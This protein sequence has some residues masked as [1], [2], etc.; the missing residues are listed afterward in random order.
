MR[1]FPLLAVLCA[2]LLAWAILFSSI[3]FDQQD[4]PLFDDWAF[5]RSALIFAKGEAIDYGHWAAMPQLGQWLWALPFIR[6]LGGSNPA[7]RAATIILSW[8]GL[9]A[10]YDLLSFRRPQAAPVAAF[11]TTV[12]AF[13]PFFFV[14]SGTFMTDIPTLS[15]C[16]IGLSL[17]QRAIEGDSVWTWVAAALIAVLA[18]CTRQN[19]WALPLAATTMLVMQAFASPLLRSGS[20]GSSSPLLPSGSAAP[21]SHLSPSGGRGQGEG[22]QPPTAPRRLRVLSWTAALLPLA[23]GSVVHMWFRARPDVLHPPL[24][25]EWR[26]GAS[27]A[28]VPDPHVVLILPFLL[29]HWLGLTAWPIWALLPRISWR[30]WLL[31]ATILLLCA[32]YWWRFGYIIPHGGLFPYWDGLLSPAGFL[33]EDLVPGKRPVIIGLRLEVREIAY[34]LY[35]ILADIQNYR[36]VAAG[37][38]CFETLFRL[39]TTLTSAVDPAFHTTIVNHSLFR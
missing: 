28:S 5:G 12:L 13:N 19:A 21:F 26:A 20:A 22:E 7:L 16:L 33:S 27:H 29:A 15:F 23:I 37:T 1:F 35:H 14:L 8:L 24:F 32:A 10:F 36:A 3:P 18:V 6:L 4:F 38:H 17:Y 31:W 11:I 30:R 9:A 25:F 34:R 39:F 2:S